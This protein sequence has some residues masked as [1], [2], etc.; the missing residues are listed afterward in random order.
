[1][2]PA[3]APPGLPKKDEIKDSKATAK[4]LPPKRELPIVPA[5]PGKKQDFALELTYVLL[6]PFSRLLIVCSF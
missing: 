2:K 4:P 1:M 5:V 6:V 3:G